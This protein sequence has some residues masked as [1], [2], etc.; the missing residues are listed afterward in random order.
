MVYELVKSPQFGMSIDQIVELHRKDGEEGD[1]DTVKKAF[2]AWTRWAQTEERTVVKRVGRTMKEVVQPLSP[3]TCQGYAKGLN[4]VFIANKLPTIKLD[5][6]AKD[7]PKSKTVITL[8]QIRETLKRAPNLEARALIMILK[9]SGLRISDICLLKV[10]DFLNAQVFKDKAGREF[11]TWNIPTK[12]TGAIANM[13]LGYESVTAI[14]D[15]LDGR[16]IG[17]IFD[18]ESKHLSPELKANNMS[19]R[20]RTYTR[21]LQKE[22]IR[23]SAHSFRHTF[24]TRHLS[25]GVPEIRI[26]MLCGKRVPKDFEGYA[27]I[28]SELLTDYAELYDKTLS[29]SDTLSMEQVNKVQASQKDDMEDMK[30]ML[31]QLMKDNQ[32]LR[33][34]LE[35]SDD[36]IE[37][38]K[39][40][41][42]PGYVPVYSKGHPDYKDPLE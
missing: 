37:R 7:N 35:R 19:K 39:V 1:G 3:Y 24:I 18:N 12:K 34:H 40:E 2:E 32:N 20:I 31:A 41:R 21:F 9:D 25:L 17:Y 8:D 29:L 22:G 27:H 15:H 5:S 28:Q 13:V 42:F 14:K 33:E 30:K 4:A 16:E 6:Y 38:L 36:E 26:K 11:R 10:Q 23:H